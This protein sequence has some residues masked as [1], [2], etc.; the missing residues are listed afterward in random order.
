MKFQVNFTP[1]AGEDL[2]CFRPYEQKM[3]V[4]AIK[5]YLREDA[6][7]E[8]SRRKRLRPTELAPWELKIG[9]YRVFYDFE[10]EGTV[11]IVAVGYKEHNELFIR[12][13]RM[14]L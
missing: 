4:A 14:E 2:K 6:N 8:S 5:G 13:R 12:G 1:S 7:I 9:K 3:I 11:K 10:G